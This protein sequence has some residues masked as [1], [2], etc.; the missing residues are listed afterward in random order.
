[1][2]IQHELK[3]KLQTLI[4][5]SGTKYLDEKNSIYLGTTRL[6]DVPG[7]VDEFFRLWF[8]RFNNLTKWFFFLREFIEGWWRNRRFI[9]FLEY[10]DVYK[11]KMVKDGTEIQ[12]RYPVYKMLGIASESHR[13]R[14]I[15]SYPNGLD[16]YFHLMKTKNAD[17][18][19]LFHNRHTIRLPFSESEKHTYVLGGTGSGKS[20][21]LKHLILQDI[22]KGEK[23]VIVIEP[24]GDLSEQIVK[25]RGI[26]PER[27]IYI[28]CSL[29][30]HTP[31][32]NPFEL[33]DSS[34]GL[35]LEK[36]SQIIRI[37]LQ[38][39]FQG[40]GQPLTLQMQS[41]LEP[42]L[43]IVAE[44]R[45]TLKDL[46]R[47]MLA[48][49][50]DDLLEAGKASPKHGEFFQR[51]FN[52]TNINSSRQGVYQKL[53]NLLN[54]TTFTDFFCGETTIDLE[55]A[56]A[57]KK[58]IVFNLSKGKLGDLASSYIGR[59]LTAII[60][61]IIF[62]RANIKE[63][64]RTPVSIFIDEFQDFINESAEQMFVQGRKYKVS[65]TV[66][67]Q[68]IGQKM[69]TE[70]TKIVLGNTNVKFVGM[71]GYETLR[72]MSKETYTE[73]EEL[74]TLSVG[75]FFCRIGN[76]EGFIL[77]VPEKHLK[78][79]TCI[80]ETDWEV[81]MKHQIQKYYKVR[82]EHGSG[83]PATP[84]LPHPKDHERKEKK[85]KRRNKENKQ[86]PKEANTI[87]PET[88]R[89]EEVR[90]PQEPPK[91]VE[92]KP[93]IRPQPQE[94]NREPEPQRPS[95]KKFTPKYK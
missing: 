8:I 75:E 10:Q 52:D 23:C 48:G 54:M 79:K 20:E 93:I 24:N 36:Q 88:K 57:E 6:R 78:W 56:V 31:S 19:S 35:E 43:E 91:E 81:Q 59:M 87:P 94:P 89:V 62:Q 85:K 66:A 61:N 80:S 2:S 28:D 64:D 90:E 32:L 50:N 14:F 63:E 77:K 3:R 73:I 95:K 71:N 17:L 41:I 86:S 60:Q 21:L 12:K 26:P 33:V 22:G 72:V 29:P 9:S 4:Y 83:S 11:D 70:M 69:S 5:P 92:Q 38:Q 65:L 13:Q 7:Q 51:K 34:H 42:C 45:G 27:L 49:A 15:N 58:V 76:G 74:K 82:P 84:T 46:Q 30:P 40:D 44:Q 16:G 53:M 39:I 47:F 18:W 55:R 37:A 68:V 1:M 25:Q 67:S